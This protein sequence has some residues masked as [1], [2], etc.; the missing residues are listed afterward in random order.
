MVANELEPADHLADGEEAQALGQDHAA[1]R[2]LCPRDVA[3]LLGVGRL[4]QAGEEGA[5]VLQL[6]P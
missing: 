1:S 2:H 3:G 6:L 5:G 4:K